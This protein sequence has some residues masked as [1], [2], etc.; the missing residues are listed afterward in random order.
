MR[1]YR[2]QD[3]GTA[4]SR[5]GCTTFW[6][7]GDMACSHLEGVTDGLVCDADI[8]GVEIPAVCLKKGF[9]DSHY[10]I[11]EAVTKMKE[12]KGGY[13]GALTHEGNTYLFR[14]VVGVKPVYYQGEAFASEKKVLPTPT[15]LLPGEVVKLPGTQVFCMQVKEVPTTDPAQVLDALTKS[16]H[17]TAEKDA[18]VL[19]SGG[20]DSSLLAALSDVPLF[21]CGL[22]GS[23][24][25]LFSRKAARL[26]DKDCIEVIISEKDIKKA[27]PAVLSIIEDHTLMNIELALLLYFICQNCDKSILIS[28]QGADELFGGYYKYEKAFRHNEDVKFAM[29][30]DFNTISHGLERDQQVAERFSKLIRYPYLDVRV[31]EKGLG[32]PVH[33]L[34]TP[35]RKGFLRTVA[36][37]VSLPDEIVFRPKKA[38]Q[39]G[40]G[41][42]KIVKKLIH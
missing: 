6:T 17:Q 12:L 3:M 42:H 34:F 31:V 27:I 41:I 16:V 26:L 23:Q 40:S 9:E 5:M 18:V 22:E 8:Y 19:F 15:A 29:R 10:N 39:Y 1:I 38:F 35:Q 28:G 14:D 25:V 32:I 13:A 30:T 7:T 21:T 24:D 37:S 33:L 20:V 11:G 4:F 2:G 36:S